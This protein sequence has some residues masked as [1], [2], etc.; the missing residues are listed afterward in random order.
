MTG[1]FLSRANTR[2]EIFSIIYCEGNGI[3]LT[4]EEIIAIGAHHGKL[5]IKHI[6]KWEEWNNGEGKH[7]WKKFKNISFNQKA[8]SFSNSVLTSYKYDALRA[9][10]QFADK[11]ASAREDKNVLVDYANFWFDFN[12]EGREKWEKRPVQKIAETNAHKDLLLLRAP[13]GAGKTDASLLW[14][15]Q[16]INVL[17][18]ADRLIIALPTRFTSN[19]LG[20]HILENI[21][22]TGIFHSTSK[23]L[24]NQDDSINYFAKFLETPATVCTIDHLLIALSKTKEEHHH[25]YFNLSNSCIVIDEADFYDEFTQANLLV[26]LE[27]LKILQIPVLLMSASL[28]QSSLSFYRQS[29]FEIDRIYADT[30]DTYNNERKRCNVIEIREYEEFEE[31]SDLLR[32][33]ISKPT[34]I[35]VN[36]VDKAVKLKKWISMSFPELKE[37]VILYHSR[38]TEED[39]AKKENQLIEALGSKAWEMGKAQGVAI[40]T[41]IGEMSVNISADFMM[42]EICPMDRLVQRFGRLSRFKTTLGEAVVL[43]PIKEGHLYP[44]PYGDLNGDVWEINQNLERTIDLLNISSYSGDDFIRLVNRVYKDGLV[45]SDKALTNANKLKELIKNNWLILP[46]FEYEEGEDSGFWKTRNITGQTMI[47]SLTPDDLE[48]SYFNSHL[49]FSKLKIEF[50][51][52]SPTYLVKKNLK[53]GNLIEKEVKIKDDSQKIILLS[54]PKMYS[55]D[56][57]LDLALSNVS[58]QFL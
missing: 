24:K 41:Q 2:H 32:K 39:K 16:Q 12:S 19:A 40:L 18:R 4:E 6:L 10:L 13:T 1:K 3:E 8:G 30:E 46:N 57:G 9:M 47:L 35:Y 28:P 44:A 7:L 55:F 52:G 31:I 42:T 26:L 20:L 45:L 14:A 11:R 43:K 23:F 36:T 27:T 34:I 58:D 15:H 54:S 22:E 33:A 25:I 49:E 5:S 38:F 21:S 53:N 56:Y 37:K 51:V 50:G 17:K 29:G 48:S